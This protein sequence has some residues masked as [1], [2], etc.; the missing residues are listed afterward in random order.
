[1]RRAVGT[2]AVAL[3]VLIGASACAS[4]PTS[5]GVQVGPVIQDQVDPQGEFV[6]TGPQK[7]STQEEILNDF[8]LAVRGPQDG[9]AIAKLFLTSALAATWNPDASTTIRTGSPLVS[10]APE[11]GL[12]YGVV[13][14]ASIDSDGRYTEE[15]SSANQSL[16]FQFTRVS[17]EWRISAAPDGIVLSESSFTVAFRQRPLYFFDPSL[18]FLV[19]DVRW[20]PS[21]PTTPVR[22]VQALL[23]GPASWLQQSL[24]T[25][26][27]ATTTLG[28]G[29]VQTVGGVTTVDLS[30]EA[31]A[32]TPDERDRMR[33]QLAVA[34][35]TPGIEITVR[36]STLSTPATSSQR[37]VV[38]PS[39][40]GAALVGTATQFGFGSVSTITPIAGLSP[41]V[42]S[43]GAVGAALSSDRQGLAILASDG[44][45]AYAEATGSS[46]TTLD[47]RSGLVVP[48][49]D[50]FRFTWSAEA[51]SAASM[52]AW[53]T[54]GVAH[55]VQTGLSPDIGIASV[56]VSRD[57]TRVVMLL[58]SP[59]GPQ[60]VV[61]GI[62]RQ[63]NV[64][65][66]LGELVELPLADDGTLGSA[67]TAIAG[68]DATWVDDRT[69]AV[70]APTATGGR[71]TVFEVGGP[72]ST[73]GLPPASVSIAGGNGGTDGLRVLSGAGSI[74]RP[75][76]SGS[77]T[78]TGIPASVLATKH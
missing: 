6:P 14:Q 42:V 76:G 45:V 51:Q 4:I 30:T 41:Q 44:S 8:M 17:D 74:W 26:F 66:G 38:N 48:S 75:L 23:L 31:L 5:G 39:V 59:V 65:I 69:V 70:L 9:Y 22:I 47:R 12:L 36:G 68:F 52:V 16:T 20:F 2:I 53:D 50:P 33:Q 34:L 77:W 15:R 72:S 29:S 28:P 46:P 54:Q 18:A 67:G 24:T 61:A 11:G 21:R 40:D 10:S 64:P 7:G 19:P 43:V 63:E 62:I 56:D 13:T 73:L 25:A 78:D 58:K 35:G 49:L 37:A 27:P 60:L 57:G 3:V 55:P 71:V 1:M 32:S